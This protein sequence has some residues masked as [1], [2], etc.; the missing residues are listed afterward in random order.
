MKILVADDSA[1]SRFI[2]LPGINGD[3]LCRR[4]RAA[5]DGPYTYFIMLTALEDKADI[6]RGM[7]AAPR[8]RQSADPG[9]PVL[10][11]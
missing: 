1:T 11:Y 2:L 5:P 4:I 8:I 7:E 9:H 6:L 3:E 10:A